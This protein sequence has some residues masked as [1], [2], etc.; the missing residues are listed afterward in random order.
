MPDAALADR[1][2]AFED[3]SRV[4]EGQTVEIEDLR[5]DHGE[6]RILCLATWQGAWS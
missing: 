6:R 5:H 3:A 2:L 4:F 1:G